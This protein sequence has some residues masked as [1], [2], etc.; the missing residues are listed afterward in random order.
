MYSRLLAKLAGA[1]I[2]AAKIDSPQQLKVKV[3]IKKTKKHSWQNIN[4]I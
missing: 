1:C 2:L 3:C 4:Y